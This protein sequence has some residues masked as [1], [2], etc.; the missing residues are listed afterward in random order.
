MAKILFV[1]YANQ[2]ATQVSFVVA[3]VNFGGVD[4][5]G[6][7]IDRLAVVMTVVF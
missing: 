3:L 5:F 1:D 4:W 7:T 2:A 6:G